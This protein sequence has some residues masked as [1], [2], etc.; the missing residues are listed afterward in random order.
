MLRFHIDRT[1]LESC[2]IYSY[3]PET[4]TL[5]LGGNANPK[6]VRI[7]ISFDDS[8]CLRLGFTKLL[9]VLEKVFN[10][11][12]S[13]LCGWRKDSPDLTPARLRLIRKKLEERG[14]SFDDFGEYVV[15]LSGEKTCIDAF[16]ADRIL[17]RKDYL[18]HH[19][20]GNAEGSNVRKALLPMIKSSAR[21]FAA[22]D[23]Y[24]IVSAHQFFG[25]CGHVV[26]DDTIRPGF[27]MILK[28]NTLL[29]LL[30]LKIL[31]LEDVIELNL[32]AEVWKK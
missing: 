32:E 14:F 5:R 9:G 19:C 27:T 11:C 21:C 26:S 30:R 12:F 24:A 13:V 16:L 29:E 31:T 17:S 25:A 15:G 7:S 8:E 10:G 18:L 20:H 2:F 22:P 3:D 6:L 4:D 1:G 23:E 28:N